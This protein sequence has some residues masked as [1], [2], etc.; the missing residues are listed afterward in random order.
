MG[1]LQRQIRK[2]QIDS[3][4]QTTITIDSFLQIKFRKFLLRLHFYIKLISR[5]ILDKSATRAQP[6]LAD[7]SG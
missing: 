3:M 6:A 4:K 5:V 1:D 2:K 7:L